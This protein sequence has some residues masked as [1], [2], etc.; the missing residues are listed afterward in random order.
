MERSAQHVGHPLC[1][2]ERLVAPR[3]LSLHKAQEQ[4]VEGAAG[5][6]E[7]LGHILEACAGPN[8]LRDVGTLPCR[9]EGMGEDGGVGC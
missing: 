5:C 9:S 4:R 2:R 1:V 7:L 6:E 8:H 3:E